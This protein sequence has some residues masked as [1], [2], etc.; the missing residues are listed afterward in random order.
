MHGKPS[1][2]GLKTE[3]GRPASW[4]PIYDGVLNA[5]ARHRLGPGAKLAEEE[6]AEI[7]G[8]S[9]TVVRAALQALARDGVVILQRN[10]GA[11]VA[12][13][14]PDEAREIFEARAVVEPP[15]AALA[16][17]RMRPGDEA[18][19]RDAIEAEHGAFHA[20][21]P[22][23]AVFH[24]ADFHRRIARLSGQRVMT[25]I[26]DGLLSR[27]SLVIAL[28]W[29]RPATLC[30]NAAHLALLR[31][32]AAGDAPGAARLMRDHVEALLADLDLR[33]GSASASD[34]ASALR[35]AP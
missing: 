31:A 21:N 20:D 33:S 30:D 5:I 22:R 13:P 27:S 14:T 4:Q 28:Y 24:S 15:L 25:A 19:L 9:R 29:R 10:K 34:L 7:Y 16:A 17:A 11:R 35:G 12:H 6:I 3:T 18:M 23:E 2:G 1:P 26:V 32:L 8:I